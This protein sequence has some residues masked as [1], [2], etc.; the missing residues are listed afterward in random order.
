MYQEKIS[1]EEALLLEQEG[2]ITIYN[3]NT[4][5]SAFSAVKEWQDNWDTLRKTYR[6]VP[7]QKLTSF[8]GF[9]YL[10]EHKF[11]DN[12]EPITTNW[13]YMYG[14][15]TETKVK[16]SEANSKGQYVYILTNIAYPGIC[17]IG[18]AVTPSKR[19]RQINSAG[20]VSEWELKYALAVSDDYKVEGMVHQELAPIRMSS[21]QGSQREFF[22]IEFEEAVKVIERVGSMFAASTPIYY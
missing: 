1:F 20:T 2:K 4:V 9:E 10:I 15:N 17:K 3:P 21:H 12:S 13:V 6:K 8:A 5:K 19:V 16:L 14:Q 7:I 22:E 18:K 11:I